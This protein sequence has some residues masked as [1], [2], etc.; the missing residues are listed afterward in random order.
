MACEITLLDLE[1]GVVCI[2]IMV[3]VGMID[4]WGG[5]NTKGTVDESSLS[6]FT[7]TLG[8]EIP[9]QIGL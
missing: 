8:N 6:R 5:G 4:S 3:N 1:I 9:K 7:D 2:Q